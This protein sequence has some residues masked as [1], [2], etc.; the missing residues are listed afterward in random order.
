MFGRAEKDIGS[1]QTPRVKDILRR[2]LV[3]P[4]EHV[5]HVPNFKPHGCRWRPRGRIFKFCKF[6]RKKTEIE[7]FDVIAENS[8]PKGFFRPNKKKSVISLLSADSRYFRTYALNKLISR[9]QNTG[10]WVQKCTKAP[11][12]DIDSLFYLVTH[13]AMI[14]VSPIDL[15][16]RVYRTYQL[17][18]R[19]AKKKATK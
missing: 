16:T 2:R 10:Q 13:L 9:H 11:Y 4:Y 14:T 7:S 1:T 5:K 12:L 8:S 19:C 3:R 6:C 18:Y 17:M 15:I